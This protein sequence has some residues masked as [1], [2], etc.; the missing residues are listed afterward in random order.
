MT[1]PTKHATSKVTLEQAQDASAK[2]AHAAARLSMI[3]AEMNERINKI[4]N[5]YYEEIVRLNE[6]KA[7]QS[8]I[9]EAYGI[10]QKENWGRKKSFELFHSII[11]FRTGSPK[12]VKDKK[13]TWEG[14]TELVK[15]QFPSFIRTHAELDKEAI[16]ALRDDALF[17]KLKKACYL[18]VV[19]SETFYVE[20]KS[21]ELQYA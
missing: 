14:I 21:E 4:R 1:H 13:F 2:F 6:E 15:E 16:I 5:E 10:D 19:Q 18:D 9:L 8:A 12:V 11:G 17:Q 20:T 3:E 7:S